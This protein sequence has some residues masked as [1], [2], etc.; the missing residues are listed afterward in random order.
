[1]E[2]FN[3]PNYFEEDDFDEIVNNVSIEML[4]IMCK[5]YPNDS[6]LGKI[7]RNLVKQLKNG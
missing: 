7:I 6:D 4:D 1:M 3:N 5:Q 2:N